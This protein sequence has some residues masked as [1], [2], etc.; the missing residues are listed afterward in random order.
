MMKM[1]RKEETTILN[2]Y[3]IRY[4]VSEFKPSEDDELAEKSKTWN[5]AVRLVPVQGLTDEKDGPN[6]SKE[7]HGCEIIVLRKT[8]RGQLGFELPR[9]GVVHISEAIDDG[10]DEKRLE[11]SFPIPSSTGRRSRFARI[12]SSDDFK[13]SKGDIRWS[14]GY[15]TERSDSYLNM[16]LGRTSR[17]L[18]SPAH[19]RE[20][21]IHA[22]TNLGSLSAAQPIPPSAVAF[23]IQSTR[24]SYL[25]TVQQRDEEG[26][27]KLSC[28]QVL[29]YR[30][31][32]QRKSTVRYSSTGEK[33]YN[34]IFPKSAPIKYN[35][36]AL[37]DSELFG[38]ES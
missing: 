12:V 3:S 31:S 15:D 2:D 8:E 26:E 16:Y 35:K 25:A 6:S 21:R 28:D 24:E 36:S 19:S 37:P 22:S 17:I 14:S 13:S 38:D 23:D 10:D 32:L 33:K 34:K 9:S 29:A 5:Y 20:S 11:E 27:H 1:R 4:R 18:R 7:N 30:Q